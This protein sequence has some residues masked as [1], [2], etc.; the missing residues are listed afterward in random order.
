ALDEEPVWRA[1]REGWRTSREYW[2]G[3]NTPTKVGVVVV[4]IIFLSNPSTW[5]FVFQVL[6]PLVLCYIVYRIGRSIVL[7]NEAQRSAAL[8]GG[9][10]RSGAQPRQEYR[11]QNPSPA[12]QASPAGASPQQTVYR[13]T[14]PAEVP[15]GDWRAASRRHW[16]KQKSRRP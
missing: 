6:P 1:I 11:P 16:R 9:Q 12:Q 3:F 4:G 13:P 2:D 10:A 7:H 15:R 14:P 8:A 5:N